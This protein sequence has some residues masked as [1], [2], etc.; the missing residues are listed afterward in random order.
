MR[1][2]LHQPSPLCPISAQGSRP[3]RSWSLALALAQ[4]LSVCVGGTAGHELMGWQVASPL[5]GFFRLVAR[6]KGPCR[7]PLRDLRLT[8]QLASCPP[9]SAPLSGPRMA[10]LG[11]HVHHQRSP[12]KASLTTGRTSR[13]M[14]RCSCH[15]CC[16]RRT[17]QQ[18]FPHL[19]THHQALGSGRG[20]PMESWPWGS[21]SIRYASQSV[22]CPRPCRDV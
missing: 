12:A 16:W 8:A 6:R 15:Q 7:W 22:Q 4:N 1:V 18:A 9:S 2:L 5:G 20:W 13:G 11:T 3:S 14:P 19:A 21:Q 17:G 10:L